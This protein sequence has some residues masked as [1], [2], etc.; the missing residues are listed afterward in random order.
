M[1]LL[2]APYRPRLTRS[3]GLA[4]RAGWTLKLIGISATGELPDRTETDAAIEIA[5]PHLPAG[6]GFA[7]LI[8]HRGEDALWVIAAWWSLDLLHHRL[9]RADLGT[10]SLQQMPPDGPTACVWELLAIDHERQAWVTHVLSHPQEPD[11]SAYVASSIQ[12]P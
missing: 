9:F 1:T 4:E 2:T 6:G 3:L 11:Y 7:F 8:V 12:I 5:A 10:T